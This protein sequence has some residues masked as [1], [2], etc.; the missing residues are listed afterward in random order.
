[1]AEREPDPEFQALS[2]AYRILAK[3]EPPARERVVAWLVSRLEADKR[4]EQAKAAER[5]GG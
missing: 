3:L 5:T 4:A 1:M 2:K